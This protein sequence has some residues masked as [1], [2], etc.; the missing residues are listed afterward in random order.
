MK[1]WYISAYDAPEGESSRTYDYA[2]ELTYMGHQVTFFTSSYN[3]FTH[4]ERLKKKEKWR[5]EWFGGIRVIWLKT[6][7]YKDNGLKRGINMLSNAWHAYWVG[8]SLE[9]KPDIIFGP[10]VPL[11]TGLSAYFLSLNKKC[12]FC[13]EVRDI[14]PQALI[15]L[16]VLSEKT[17]ITWLLRKIEIFL[18]RRANKIIAALPFAYKHICQYGISPERVIWIPNGVNLKRFSTCKAYSGG[19]IDSL[20]VMY[21]GRFAAGHGTEVILQSARILQKNFNLK[22]KFIFVGDGPGK[23]RFEQKMQEYGIKNI[24][25]R[26]AVPKSEIPRVLEKADLLIASLQDISIY[27]FGINLNKIYD[28]LASGRPI[29]FAANAPNNPI[30]DANAGISIPPENSQAM[31]EAIKTIFSM[32]PEKRRILGENGRRYAERHYD[33]RIL[34]KKLENILLKEIHETRRTQ[35]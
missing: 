11:F 13:F 8:R 17:P 19:G 26:K 22:I 28:Y 12:S 31:V 5:V 6:F 2:K 30:A 9:E 25:L 15:D 35:T 18:Y 10:S 24:E 1:I 29:I 3:H 21:V 27:Q 7:P 14:W 20:V 23:I 34:A 32:S 33:I 16:G 4:K